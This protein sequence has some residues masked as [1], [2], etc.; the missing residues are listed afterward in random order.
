GWGKAPGGR[1]FLPSRPT[2]TRPAIWSAKSRGSLRSGRRKSWSPRLA[3]AGRRW[4]RNSGEIRSPLLW[5]RFVVTAFMP[6]G[7]R[8]EGPHSGG[9]GAV[10]P[11]EWGHY[12]P[13]FARARP[14]RFS[15]PTDRR[16]QVKSPTDGERHLSQGAGHWSQHTGA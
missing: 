4:S 12:D 10:R 14:R 7:G 6:S 9:V 2:R 13:F 1:A 15:F 8:S 11:H 3:T 5:R 16:W